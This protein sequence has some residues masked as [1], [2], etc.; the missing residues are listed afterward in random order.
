MTKLLAENKNQNTLFL[1]S[2]TV[3]LLVII[4]ISAVITLFIYEGISNA[5]DVGRTFI[6]KKHY[7][8]FNKKTTFSEAFTQTPLTPGIQTQVKVWDT[9]IASDSSRLEK[10]IITF[11]KQGNK[12]EL[13]FLNNK[14]ISKSF[15]CSIKNKATFDFIKKQWNSLRFN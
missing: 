12:M 6:T 11:D 7:D 2:I 9:Y 13:K 4:N 15:A 10:T 5:K 14:L 3:L 8:I 1:L